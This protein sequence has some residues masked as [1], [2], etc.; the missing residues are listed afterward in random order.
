MIKRIEYID[1]LKSFAI[2]LVVV[3]HAISMIWGNSDGSDIPLYVF[4]YSFH[5]PLFMFLSGLC[6]N[7]AVLDSKILLRKLRTLL[8]PYL[9]WSFIRCTIQGENFIDGVIYRVHGGYWFL[10]CLFEIFLLF[11]FL[12]FLE[13]RVN[14]TASV[15]KDIVFWGM[16]ALGMYV[17]YKFLIQ[18]SVCEIPLNLDMLKNMWP[19]FI[20]GYLVRKHMVVEKFFVDEKKHTFFV[21]LF[22]SLLWLNISRSIEFNALLILS[23]GVA[24][25]VTFY[26]FFRSLALSLRIHGIVNEIGT[27]TLNI[28]I[29]HVFFFDGLSILSP[30]VYDMKENTI[31]LLFISIVVSLANILLCWFV[32]KLLSQN[33]YLLLLLF[34]IKK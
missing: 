20:F 2:L 26:G 31:T 5:M 3:G 22:C 19:F 9:L 10:L 34:G 29:L 7:P 1:N 18:H 17:I 4:I 13:K 30:Y 32:N 33:K 21:L 6:V 8:W 27:I 16:M 12:R 25:I 24:G 23:T 11:I 28:Y 14:P 15:T